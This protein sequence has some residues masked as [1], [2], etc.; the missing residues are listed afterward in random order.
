MR[1]LINCYQNKSDEL[2]FKYGWFHA[3]DSEW[4]EK[5]NYFTLS[6]FFSF[7]NTM[8]LVVDFTLT[9]KNYSQ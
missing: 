8:R 6:C 2:R 9:A 3:L 7:V 4:S 5:S 1:V